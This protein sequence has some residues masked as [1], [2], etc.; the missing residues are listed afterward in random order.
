M[1]PPAW[2]KDPGPL[3][4][5]RGF[6]LKTE[7]PEPRPRPRKGVNM[8]AD[9]RRPKRDS[10]GPGSACSCVTK[11]QFTR[12]VSDVLTFPFEAHKL[13]GSKLLLVVTG[14]RV[15]SRFY[16]YDRDY[17]YDYDLRLAYAWL[18]LA[19]SASHTRGS[20]VF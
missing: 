10:L 2:I 1:L 9:L 16:D 15:R 19:T 17:D 5:L 4:T 6:A 20:R 13:F 12:G 11:L 8:A 18:G 14:T 7:N 3:A